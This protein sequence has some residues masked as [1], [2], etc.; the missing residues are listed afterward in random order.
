MRRFWLL[1]AVLGLTSPAFADG[2]CTAGK[3][4]VAYYIEWAIYGR[5]FQPADIPVSKITHLNYAFANVGA[6]GR[7]AQGDSYAATDKYYPGDTWD[8]PFRGTYNR[9]NNIIKPANPHL[10]TIISV[11]GWTW[12]GRFSD[13]ALTPTSR[14][15]FASSCVDFMRQYHWDGVDVDWEYPVGGGLSTN[16]YRPGDRQNYT[17]LLQEMRSQFDTAGAADGK[18]YILT[19]AAPAG[20]DKMANL[21]MGPIAA[22]VDWVNVITYDYFGAWDLSVTGHHAGLDANPAMPS[23]PVDPLVRDRYNVRWTTQAWLGAMSDAGV[24]PSKLVLGTPFYGHGWGGVT[25]GPTHGLFRSATS[26]PP[27]TWDDWSSGATGVNDYTQ[28]QQFFANGGYSRFWDATSQAPY[29][30]NAA[31]YGGHFISY[32]DT[33]SIGIK[34]AYVHQQHLGGMM[35]WE[36]TGDRNQELLDAVVAG[37]SCRADF[38]CSGSVSVQDLFG[39]LAAWFAQD[40]R[41]DFNGT[42]GVTVQDLFDYLAAWFAGC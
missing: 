29:L 25:A 2:P 14:A 33:Q 20:Y 37:M 28:V 17:L 6:D 13:V 35:I 23:P 15:T 34:A 30:Y 40:S 22:I 41:A 4:I 18:H 32:E 21:E 9:I 7:I 12:S 36:I 31:A 39:F 5:N 42:G 27:G 19:I 8:Q 3:R 38:D 1:L 10:K 24:L 16:T 11:G 26:V